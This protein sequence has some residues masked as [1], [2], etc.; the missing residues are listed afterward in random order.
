M[1]RIQQE[2]KSKIEQ[3]SIIKSFHL[4]N[5]HRGETAKKFDVENRQMKRLE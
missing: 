2:T 5:F 3:I 4:L 1:K